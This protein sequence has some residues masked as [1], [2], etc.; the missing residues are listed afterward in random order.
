M[1]LQGTFVWADGRKYEGEW[2]DGGYHGRGEYTH[3]DGSQYQV[4]DVLDI[5]SYLGKGEWK[6]N[7]RNGKGV[8]SWSDGDKFEGEWSD[9][10]RIG[11]GIF[12]SK[13]MIRLENH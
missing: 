13:V 6:D 3:R 5:Y 12:I 9:G 2:K 11:R 7:M 8:F 4:I 1:E 10:R